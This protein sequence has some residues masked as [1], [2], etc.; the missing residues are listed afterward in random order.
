M[1][2]ERTQKLFCIG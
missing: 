2:P 1:E